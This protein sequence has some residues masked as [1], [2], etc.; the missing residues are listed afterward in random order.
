MKGGKQL[1]MARCLKGVIPLPPTTGTIA[2]LAK[3]APLNFPPVD[4]LTTPAY[5][6]CL[7]TAYEPSMHP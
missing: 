5:H 7:G 2:T 4:T 6:A 1:G 3:L